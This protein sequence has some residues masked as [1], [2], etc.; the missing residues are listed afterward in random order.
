MHAVQPAVFVIIP[1]RNGIKHLSYSLA[2]LVKT[3]YV[4]YRIVLVDDHSTD[5]SVDFVERQYP[6]VRVLENDENKGFAGAANVGIA[7]ALGQGA[8]FIAIFNSDIKVL[9]EWL[10]CVVDLFCKK[11]DI[12]LV[13][14]TE[15]P[16]E[17]EELF[18]EVKKESVEYQEVK[19]L[20]GCLYVCPSRVFKHVGFFDEAYFMYS[21]D[22]DFFSRLTRSGYAILKTN[23]PVW[24]YGEGSSGNRQFF[25]TWLAY[26]N[27]LRFAI[28][29]ESIIGIFRIFLSLCN[30]GC[31]LFLKRKADPNFKR[32]RRYNIITN[33]ALITASCCWNLFYLPKTIGL[34]TSG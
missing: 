33:F 29:N 23:M 4:N 24:H 34:R 9:P 20:C 25:M 14:F 13:G 17:K 30:Q 18:R 3:T 16:K 7:Y 31:N 22:N 28:K 21:E 15:I 5:E 2:S 11:P 8:D 6:L 32:L 10:E 19:S 27:T 1:N 12:G 26:R